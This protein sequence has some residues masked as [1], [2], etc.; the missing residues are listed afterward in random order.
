MKE[1]KSDVDLDRGMLKTKAAAELTGLSV[2]YI[3]K[4]IRTKQ[5]K[6]T[7]IGRNRL[8]FRSEI[9]RLVEAGRTP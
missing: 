1:R 7:R 3:K 9:D 6:T 5:L 8:I 4:L 2:V